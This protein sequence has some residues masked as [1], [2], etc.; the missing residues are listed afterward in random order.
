[1]TR[2]VSVDSR[3]RTS[4]PSAGKLEDLEFVR[5]IAAFGVVIY[6]FLLAFFPP[7]AS[8]HFGGSVALVVAPP[9]LISPV[10]GP[11]LVSVFF[12]LSSFVLTVKLVHEPSW[13]GGVVGILKRFPRLLPLTVIGSLLPAILLATG[14]MMNREAALLTGS[15]WQAWSGGVKEGGNWPEAS[16]LGGLRD[17]ILLFE[18]GLSQF[19]SALW[20]M[21]Y[22]LVGSVAA[23]ATAMVLGARRR[24]LVDG[25]IVLAIGGFAIDIH[26]LISIC[27]AT[28]WLTKYLSLAR[29]RIGRTLAVGLIVTGLLIGSTYEIIPADYTS[30]DWRVL[31]ATR[32]DWLL[33]GLGAMVLFVGVRSLG[34]LPLQR[35]GIGRALGR[36]SFPIYVLH[37]PVQASVAAAIV[38]A[39]GNT[40]LGVGIAFVV[41]TIVIFLVAWPVAWL[42]EWW[43]ARL[44]AF[45]R[46]FTRA[47]ALPKTAVRDPAP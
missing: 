6:H 26:P 47:R 15:E 10:N 25:L 24:P 44:G 21:K 16:I 43:V 27:V 34:R 8:P 29:D 22:E 35:H 9:V 4:I 13:R 45:F 12:V 40:A 2:A 38:V 28:V 30:T 42:D 20:T 14:L 23:I 36:F 18:R 19:N 37:I 33:H 32:F 41:S 7:D 5:G 39:L 1:M 11:F 31:Q 3:G 46:R 17:S